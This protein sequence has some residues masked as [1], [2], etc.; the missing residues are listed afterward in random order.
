MVFTAW[1]SETGPALIEGD[2]VKQGISFGRTT[3]NATRIESKSFV[4]CQLAPTLC[5]LRNVY[6]T[7]IVCSDG[8]Q[9]VWCGH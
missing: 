2:E 7:G 5:V 6:E 4:H 8:F 9:K 1:I 3:T